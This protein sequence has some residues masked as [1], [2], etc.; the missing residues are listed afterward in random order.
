MSKEFEVRW[1]AEFAGAPQQVWDAITKHAGAWLWPVEYEPRVGGAERGLSSG[2]G[3]VTVWEPP[4]RFA[5]RAPHG[6]GF[7]QIDYDLEPRGAGTHVRYLHQSVAEDD[8]EIEACHV[9]TDFYRHS[10]GEY[11]R[12]FAGREAVYVGADGPEVSADGG[13]AAVCRALGLPADVAVGDQVRLTPAGL[14]PLEGVVDYAE[15]TFLGVRTADALFRIYGREVWGWPVAVGHHSFAGPAES[16]DAWQA[17]LDG[18]FASEA[19]A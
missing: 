1:E 3:K 18:V 15:G 10:M 9:H 17:W 19:V 13:F 14:Q 11:V 6:D 7:N 5:T 12:H 16:A 2:G 4:R 8:A